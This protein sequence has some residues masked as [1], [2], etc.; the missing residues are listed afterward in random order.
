MIKSNTT[1]YWCGFSNND[2][3]SQLLF[4]QPFPAIRSIQEYTKKLEFSQNFL[5]CPAFRN[6]FKNV[7]ELNFPCDY[8]M[9]F[10]KNADKIE[11]A[12]DLHD[13]NFYDDM[14]YPRAPLQNLYSYNLRYLFYCEDPLKA[15]VTPAYMSENE[16][17]KNTMLI[18][19]EFDV[20]QWF[21]PIECAFKVHEGCNQIY[22]EKSKPFSYI[23]FKT[24]K[25]IVFKRFFMTDKMKKIMDDLIH[26]RLH[27]GSE[28]TPLEKLYQLYNKLNYTKIIKKEIKNNLMD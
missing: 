8:E 26:T 14:V 6:H 3:V 28:F 15:N 22:F 1:V 13:Q 12:S 9:H 24:E 4:D 7:F 2:I 19:G 11:I 21:R 23:H 10:T 18:S 25:Q 27:R 17:T 16:F 20:G 5:L